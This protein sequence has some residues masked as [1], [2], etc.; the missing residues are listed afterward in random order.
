MSDQAP[1]SVDS[2]PAA[3]TPEAGAPEIEAEGIGPRQELPTDRHVR[4]QSLGPLDG[5]SKPWPWSLGGKS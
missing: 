1:C 2:P 5:C 4:P 3:E